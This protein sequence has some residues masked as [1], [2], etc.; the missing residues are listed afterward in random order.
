[1]FKF[2]PTKQTYSDPV[3]ATFK[4]GIPFGRK[5]SA[6]DICLLHEGFSASK[7]FL[8]SKV[9]RQAI[10]NS[11]EYLEEVLEIS[12]KDTRKETKQVET[13]MEVVEANVAKTKV[14]KSGKKL[15]LE[16]EELVVEDTKE[17]TNEEATV[18]EEKQ[19]EASN[20]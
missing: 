15:V 1:M 14:P 4:P 10:L 17:T 2:K 9:L 13:N 6:G 19:E 5:Y 12:I 20:K 3:A 8:N 18:T 11:K 7:V 16:T